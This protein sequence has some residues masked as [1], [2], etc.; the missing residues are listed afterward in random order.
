MKIQITAR[1]F[2]LKTFLITLP[3][4]IIATVFGL[5]LFHPEPAWKVA[6]FLLVGNLVTTLTL[7]IRE[8]CSERASHENV[9]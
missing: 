2:S 4:W 8:A 9:T 3:I 1:K 6:V 5:I 7:A